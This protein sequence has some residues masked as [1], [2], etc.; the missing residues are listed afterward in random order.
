MK[1]IIRH[2][3]DKKSDLKNKRCTFKIKKIIINNFGLNL[4]FVFF[5]K[6]RFC[7]FFLPLFTDSNLLYRETNFSSF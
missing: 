4:R 2:S 7:I 1:N 5:Y 6:T 3:F